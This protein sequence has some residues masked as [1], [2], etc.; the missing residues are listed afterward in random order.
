MQQER[1][2]FIYNWPSKEFELKQIFIER[3]KE[4]LIIIFKNPACQGERG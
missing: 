4:T 1:A 3:L 2:K